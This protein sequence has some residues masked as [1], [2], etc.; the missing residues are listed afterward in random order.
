MYSIFL[1]SKSEI[2]E[3]LR[4]LGRNSPSC[5][6]TYLRLC[7]L[8]YYRRS[9]STL[10]SLFPL[11]LPQAPTFLRNPLNTHISEHG[12]TQQVRAAGLRN[13]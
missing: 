4:A 3:I 13:N 2:S 12:P 1:V 8:G 11:F 7:S 10:S 6:N 5:L 9:S